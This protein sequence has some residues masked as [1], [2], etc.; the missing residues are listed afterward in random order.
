MARPGGNPGLVN[1]QFSTD[2]DENQK[3]SQKITIRITDLMLL[4]LQEKGSYREYCRR[5][6]AEALA[7]DERI[8]E[9]LERDSQSSS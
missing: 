7:R 1:H 5:A 3:L 6:I 4:Q 8:A 2:R 9:K